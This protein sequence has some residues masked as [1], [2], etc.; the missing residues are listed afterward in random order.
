MTIDRTLVAQVQALP[1]FAGLTG[2][3]IEQIAAAMKPHE[4]AAGAAV[5]VEDEGGRF[6]RLFMIVDG[7]AAATVGGHEVATYGP[8]DSFGELSVL[9]GKPRSATVTATTPLSTF[10]LASWNLRSLM[11]EHP[12]I[13]FH[14]VDLLV[15]RV[16]AADAKLID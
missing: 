10:G 3:C 12:E 14:L 4:F 1:L 2:K 9:D 6:G 15:A 13:A 8:G 16:R 11:Q 5:I 7:T